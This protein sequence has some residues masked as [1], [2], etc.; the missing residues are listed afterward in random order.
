[1]T[2][3]QQTPEKT[4]A[5]TGLV[6]RAKKLYEDRPNAVVLGLM[7]FGILAYIAGALLVGDGGSLGASAAAWRG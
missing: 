2:E 3:K 7:G 5:R 6:A 4:P 1:M